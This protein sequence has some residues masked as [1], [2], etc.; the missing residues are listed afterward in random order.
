MSLPGGLS[1]GLAFLP[2]WL[3][4]ARD[5]LALDAL[6]SGWV[7]TS[8][9]RSAGL[10]W[11]A[12]AGPGLALLAKADGVERLPHHPPEAPEVLKGLRGGSA[13]VVWQ[14][15]NSVGR[16]YTQMSP[17]GRPA[18][19]IWAERGIGDPWSEAERNY[20]RLSARLI[21]R[22][23]ALA[24]QIG[25]VV[26]PDR[27]QQR[28]GD[29]SVIAGRMA[30]DFD[31]ILTGIIGFAD[32]TNPLVPAGSQAARFIGE[33][34]KVGQRGIAFT[35]QLHQL[36]RSGQG[37]PLPGSVA[38]AV[39]KEETRLRSQAQA[40]LHL[41]SAVPANLSAVA[42]DGGPLSVVLGHLMENATDATPP[43]GRVLVSARTVELSPADAKG[44]L[45]QV[46]LGP[47]IEITVQDSGPGIKPEVRAKLFVEPFYTTKVRHRGLGLAIVYRTLCAHRG[48]IRLE[49]VPP[50]ETGTVAR[51][52]I[53][54][55]T[56]R[57][58]VAPAAVASTTAIGG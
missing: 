10:V 54:P 13:T 24:A 36:S 25:P 50:P 55:A 2:S 43:G 5:A 56:V 31:N 42:M 9:W 20:L 40:G 47:H 11:P 52:V 51:V 22:S 26:D 32:L 35:Q 44:Y 33:I 16:L 7:R 46:G 45:G 17:P 15:P 27:L 48:G 38:A 53:P 8:G 3:N 18:G 6:L 34:G 28:L 12:D 4:D 39:T 58:A 57:P 1:A 49:S 37:K 41:L 23:P 14:V 19:L 30:H 29:A 21:E